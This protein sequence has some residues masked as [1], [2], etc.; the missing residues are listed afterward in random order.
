M[1][2][3]TRSEKH[4]HQTM[5]SCASSLTSTRRQAGKSVRARRRVEAAPM[6]RDCLL[7][8]FEELENP[9]EA[10]E[11]FYLTREPELRDLVRRLAGLDYDRRMDA[12]RLVE[13]MTR[14]G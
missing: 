7:A 12:L 3:T 10:I 11:I 1:G 9:G 8:M 5:N 4:R 14:T 6:L 2:K 13:G